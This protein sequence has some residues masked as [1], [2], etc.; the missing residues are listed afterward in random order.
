MWKM[1]NK[2]I[3]SLPFGQLGRATATLNLHHFS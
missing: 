1:H 3:M 2:Y